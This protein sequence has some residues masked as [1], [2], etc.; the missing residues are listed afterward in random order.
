MNEFGETLLTP[1]DGFTVTPYEAF[2][3]V[4]AR[5]AVPNIELGI[6]DPLS[7]NQETYDK[8]ITALEE[9]TYFDTEIE[10]FDTHPWRHTT[11]TQWKVNTATDVERTVS[12]HEESVAAVQEHAAT[13]AELLEIDIESCSRFEAAVDLV[14][15]FEIQPDVDWQSHHLAEEFVNLDNR[16]EEFGNH[17]QRIGGLR[18]ELQNS[19]HDSFHV[20]P[21][22]LYPGRVPVAP[23]S[24]HRTRRPDAQGCEPEYR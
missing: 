23:A 13:I 5:R 15:H 21:P 7:L 4:A 19:Y 14:E 24:G 9:L 10:S 6:D 20:Q 8:A 3:I 16:L 1:P 22:K 2:G 11:L 18:T 17:L 12:S